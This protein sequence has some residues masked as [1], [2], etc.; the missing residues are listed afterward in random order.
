[1]PKVVSSDLHALIH[2]LGKSE[3]RFFKLQ[4][5]KE[6]SG[7]D[8]LYLAYF[9]AADRQTVYDEAV[10]IGKV[11]GLTPEN[12]ANVK[13]YLKDMLMRCLRS[14]HSKSTVDARLHTMLHDIGILFSKGLFKQCHL[15][16]RKA[17]RL[18]EKQD[19][20]YF[21]FEIL[22]W[23]RR[24][25]ME[26]IASK[27]AARAYATALEDGDR[28]LEIQRNLDQYSRLFYDI[29]R[30]FMQQS[31]VRSAEDRA[32]YDATVDHPLLAD[33]SCALSFQARIL[34][35]NILLVYAEAVGDR[36]LG[37]RCGT[38]IRALFEDNPDQI[39]DD[40]RRYLRGLN[41]LLMSQ[42]RLSREKEFFET[43]QQVRGLPRR[44]R[45]DQSRHY[46]A[47]AFSRSY[48]HELSLYYARKDYPRIM[49]LQPEVEAGLRKYASDM[50]DQHL[51][52]IYHYFA[53]AHLA[54]ADV[55]GALRW[56]NESL[57][58]INKYSRRDL[59]LFARI[60]TIIVH[61]ELGNFDLIDYM[62]R[63]SMS[64]LYKRSGLFRFERTFLDF[65][66]KAGDW[67]NAAERAKA[68]KALQE[69]FDVLKEDPFENAAM[70]I[71]DIRTWVRHKVE[72]RPYLDVLQEE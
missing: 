18:A 10:L 2:S 21:L 36:D 52:V 39:R 42:L 30:M 63:S 37:Y 13:L 20:H 6:A 41:N 22:H 3:K 40:P 33:E 26:L 7:A 34:Y 29:F 62:M 25:A 16:V 60:F 9:D 51:M 70:G 56:I 67:K 65:I 12:V 5:Q 55:R 66:R 58:V 35:N 19:R 32:A 17:K 38:R 59:K 71:L 1:M 31:F 27:D 46:E 23:D 57:K 69:K 15:L 28:L 14:Y 45:S 50:T 72:G 61:F 64:Y 4:A 48:P 44:V 47:M 49:A 24:I 11:E 8:A 68:F 54:C 43:L 53:Q